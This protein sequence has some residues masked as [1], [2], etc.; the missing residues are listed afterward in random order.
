MY[1]LAITAYAALAA[2][3]VA[4][5]PLLDARPDDFS[6]RL[7]L[8]APAVCLCLASP[9]LV[10]H[11]RERADAVVSGQERRPTGA[12]AAR[13][14]RPTARSSNAPGGSKWTSTAPRMRASTSVRR[15][16]RLRW[17]LRTGSTAWSAKRF[18]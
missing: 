15:G 12:G 5:L 10:P 6:A 16:G 18:P 11:V 4:V 9:T 1:Q 8:V 14:G 17:A 13:G 2:Y 3:V 7:L